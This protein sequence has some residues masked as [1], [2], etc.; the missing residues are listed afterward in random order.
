MDPLSLAAGHVAGKLIDRFSTSFRVNVIERWSRAR[1]ATYFEQFCQ[2]IETELAGGQSDQLDTLLDQLLQDDYATEVM[3]DAYRSVVMS[4]SKTI[5]PRLVAVLTAR[6]VVEQRLPNHR[7]E[8][9]LWAAEELDDDELL[10]FAK[11]VH[12]TREEIADEFNEDVSL[13]NTIVKIK[14]NTEE[15]QTSRYGS[16]PVSMSPLNLYD[17]HGSWAVKLSTRDVIRTDM[18]EESV[19]H[20]GDHEYTTRYITW[21]IET[22]DSYFEFADIIDRVS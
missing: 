5:G 14:W 21:W 15:F 9:F 17:S 10:A 13:D 18:T 6:L 22:W 7:E 20:D 12:K 16:E 11:F 8:S 2:E 1:A 19:T 4:R 3:F